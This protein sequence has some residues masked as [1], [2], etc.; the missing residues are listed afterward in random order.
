MIQLRST[1][2][3]FYFARF[4]EAGRIV[5]WQGIKAERRNDHRK[6]LKVYSDFARLMGN[7]TRNSYGFDDEMDSLAL[8]DLALR[9]DRRRPGNTGISATV[10]R[11]LECEGRERISAKHFSDY[12]R[13]HG[14]IGLANE[15]TQLAIS[16]GQRQDKLQ[17]VFDGSQFYYGLPARPFLWAI[18]LWW[19]ASLLLILIPM[20]VFW[21]LFLDGALGWAQVPTVPVERRDF[22]KSLFLTVGLTAC[23]WGIAFV[24]GAGWR[25]AFFIGWYEDM[26]EN[27]GLWTNVLLA[28]GLLMPGLAATIACQ[29][30][31]KTRPHDKHSS[32]WRVTLQ[33]V[34]LSSLLAE[35][36]L[37]WLTAVAAFW[38]VACL[39]LR[40]PYLYFAQSNVPIS[41]E[42]L[43]KVDVLPLIPQFVFATGLLLMWFREIIATPQVQ[44]GAVA[45]RLR[46]LHATFGALLITASVS[47]LL[48]L[49]VSLPV[50]AAADAEMVQL[51]Q[52]GEVAMMLQ[53]E[54]S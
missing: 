19:S 47:Y 40:Y 50:R 46:L 30:I 20:I 31:V 27:L 24:Y 54:K 7:A 17:R 6:A 48:L 53:N 16:G 3:N 2:N 42:F 32:R 33:N 1:E 43:E 44:K 28:V 37:A 9:G 14:R 26:P 15:M 10:Y 39:L 34:R 35:T 13:A 49:A 5:E 45:K 11:K 51:I 12:A 22:L 38:W 25:V 4:R 52:H 8:F 21:W 36:A 18:I 41:P 29:A 23:C